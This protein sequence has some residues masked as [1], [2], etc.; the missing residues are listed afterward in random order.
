[1]RNQYELTNEED[2]NYTIRCDYVRM[3][4]ETKT[5]FGLL[6]NQE[7]NDYELEDEDYTYTARYWNYNYALEEPVK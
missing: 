7:F 5:K 3:D 6:E 1:M 2:T 4:K